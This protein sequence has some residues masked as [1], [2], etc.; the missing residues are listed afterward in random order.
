[1]ELSVV[2]WLV[3]VGAALAS[4]T[5]SGVI[6]MG[7]GM[8]L[9]GVLAALL[10]PAI[11][12]PVHG[13]AQLASNFTRTLALLRHVS[14]RLFALYTPF[15]VVGTALAAWLWSRSS[16]DWF[17]PA[18]GVF[19]LAFLVYR[20]RK[21]ALRNPPRWVYAPLGIVTGFLGVFVGATGPFIAPFFQRDDLGKESIIATKAAVQSVGHLLKLPAFLVL[22]FD[23]L[24]WT[25]LL[26]ALVAAVIAGTLLGRFLLDK[27]SRTVF[28]ALFEGTLAL[29]ALY[30]VL[31]ALMA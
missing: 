1:M 5:L 4:S 14:W 10:P 23:Y 22:G 11:V 18:I 21:P 17:K 24:A 31:G 2:A 15:L 13:V 29:I 3:V 25:P 20:R 9:V 16:L 7:G 6:G 28:N 27:L 30:L 12:V 19:L 8:T 26:L